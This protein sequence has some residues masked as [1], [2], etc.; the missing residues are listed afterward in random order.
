MSFSILNCSDI[1]SGSGKII[2][3]DI[4][5]L[6][7]VFFFY[8]GCT[9][10]HT[11]AAVRAKESYPVLAEGL[12]EVIAEVIAEIN[13]VKEEGEIVVGGCQH[14]LEFFLGGDYKVK[15]DLASY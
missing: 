14:P 7:T 8:F 15:L 1:L 6:D 12:A 10:N 13:S 4:I 9:G 11:I 2:M 3:N 5:A